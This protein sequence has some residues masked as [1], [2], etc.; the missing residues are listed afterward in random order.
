MFAGIWCAFGA[1]GGC[2]PLLSES[3]VMRSNL[4]LL[5]Q[6]KL[7]PQCAAAQAI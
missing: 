3:A 1:V 2:T 6:N 5:A 4:Q 7:L